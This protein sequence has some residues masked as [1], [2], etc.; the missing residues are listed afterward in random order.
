MS[1]LKHQIGENFIVS[2]HILY[3]QVALPSGLD[4]QVT[5]KP[6]N[7]E[8]QKVYHV[9]IRPIQNPDAGGSAFYILNLFVKKVSQ[10]LTA[11]RLNYS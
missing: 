4:T 1:N 11:S 3:L 7:G 10:T 5:S 6:K 9:I 8:E 2:D